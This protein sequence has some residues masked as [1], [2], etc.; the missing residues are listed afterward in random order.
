MNKQKKGKQHLLTKSE[1][2]KVFDLSKKKVGL[3]NTDCNDI[4]RKQVEMLGLSKEA[5]QFIHETYK[6]IL[7]R[8][9][10]KKE[11]VLNNDMQKTGF[12]VKDPYY[13]A[14]LKPLAPFV[15]YAYFSNDVS[16]TQLKSQYNTY[17][18]N[19]GMRE[20]VG[21]TPAMFKK[22]FYSHGADYDVKLKRL[23]L[24]SKLGVAYNGD[25]DGP[26]SKHI[27]KSWL[28]DLLESMNKTAKN[29][30]YKNLKNSR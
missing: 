22:R 8:K 24:I 10:K 21:R 23:G 26:S 17:A 3:V 29:K 4:Y 7:S 11:Q 16:T 1:I 25:S 5:E 27:P 28:V 9:D 13:K 15:F 12:G 18:I 6:G 14:C 19:E 20:E 2:A 30:G